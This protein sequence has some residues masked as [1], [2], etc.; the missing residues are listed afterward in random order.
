MGKPLARQPI[1]IAFVVAVIGLVGVLRISMVPVLLVLAPISIA[2]AW[3]R[4]R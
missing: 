3:V 1:A 4:R 2:I